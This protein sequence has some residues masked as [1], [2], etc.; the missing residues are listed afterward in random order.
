MDIKKAEWR[1]AGTMPSG[2]ETSRAP[3]QWPNGDPK[4]VRFERLEF[5][6]RSNTA[7]RACGLCK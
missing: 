1:P 7:E 2:A 6:R 3:A 4:A 5:V